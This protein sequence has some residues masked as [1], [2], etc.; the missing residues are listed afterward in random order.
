MGRILI[1]SIAELPA[2]STCGNKFE[3]YLVCELWVG[4]LATLNGYAEV[5][6]EQ[7]D[8]DIS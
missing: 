7:A 3:V 6:V 2:Q 8:G 4:S 5:L 1:R